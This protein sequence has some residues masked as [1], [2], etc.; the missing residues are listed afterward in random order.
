MTDW[1]QGFD[2]QISVTAKTLGGAA[3]AF[4]D[5]VG[6]DIR[7]GQAAVN[8][9]VAAP[10]G[11]ATKA[12]LNNSPTAMKVAIGVAAIGATVYEVAVRGKAVIDFYSEAWD[13]NSDEKRNAIARAASLR[14]AKDA[15]L[16]TEGSVGLGIGSLGARAAVAY[17]PR[18]QELAFAT[19]RRVEYGTR[20]IMPE[21]L[22]FHLPGSRKIGADII[23]S[24]GSVN[25]A[26]LT[27]DFREPWQGVERIRSIDLSTRRAS[28]SLPGTPDSVYMGFPDRPNMITMH[29]HPPGDRGFPSRYDLFS[30]DSL[31][32]IHSDTGTTIFKGERTNWLAARKRA[33]EALS[34]NTSGNIASPSNEDVVRK[35]LKSMDVRREMLVFDHTNNTAAIERSQW[36]RPSVRDLRESGITAGRAGYWHDAESIALDYQAA[37][38]SLSSF[39]VNQTYSSFLS[40]LEASARLAQARS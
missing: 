36:R 28:L 3:P 18:L 27:T 5:E 35:A 4:L 22:W 24:D 6:N 13:A 32:I 38:R 1:A 9:A 11:F 26:K 15:A 37:T 14:V 25:I 2:N 10:I 8:V 17:S 34:S 30:S 31:N 33:E 23:S 16:F 12:L 19:T 40:Q 39:N 7:S 20:A 21:K 29:L